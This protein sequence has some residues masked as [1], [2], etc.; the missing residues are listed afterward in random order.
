MT[1]TRRRAPTPHAARQRGQAALEYALAVAVLALLLFVLPWPGTDLAVVWYF[2]EQLRVALQN[3][4]Y[5]LST[6]F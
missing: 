3:T 1:P 6:A 2:L 5:A 4:L